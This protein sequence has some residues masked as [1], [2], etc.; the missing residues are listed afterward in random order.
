MIRS[1]SE[2][3]WNFPLGVLDRC[4]VVFDIGPQWCPQDSSN[5][6]KTEQTAVLSPGDH[7]TDASVVE[8]ALTEVR[9]RSHGL[10]QVSHGSALSI[11][12]DEYWVHTL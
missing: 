2:N 1:E 6:S 7:G 8:L 10:N 11:R 9:P 12:L 3:F 4:I 5:P